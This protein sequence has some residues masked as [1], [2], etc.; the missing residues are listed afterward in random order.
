MDESDTVYIL[1]LDNLRESAMIK[2]HLLERPSVNVETI[3]L[4]DGI[5]TPG[6]ALRSF[7]SLGAFPV[8][9]DEM[10]AVTEI[11]IPGKIE[12][13]DVSLIVNYKEGESILKSSHIN[14]TKLDEIV[15]E[16]PNGDRYVMHGVYVT[17]MEYEEY[18]G[19]WTF[20]ASV[21]NLEM[22]EL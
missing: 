9:E 22:M 4:R 8:R 15:G 17:E 2:V 19:R 13:Q 10:L 1:H 11:K 18:S 20:T 6:A 5:P 16:D 12:I 3:T 21:D 7:L 14:R